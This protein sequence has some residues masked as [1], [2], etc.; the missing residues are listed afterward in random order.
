MAIASEG[1]G[2]KSGARH[3]REHVQW[4]CESDERRELGRA[5]G[6]MPGLARHPVFQWH[7]PVKQRPRGSIHTGV[8]GRRG[9]A[10]RRPCWFGRCF[11]QRRLSCESLL[12][13]CQTRHARRF[14]AANWTGGGPGLRKDT[15]LA[16]LSAPWPMDA[17][18][19]L[20][21]RWLALS[22]PRGP[23]RFVTPARVHSAGLPP[24]SD[25]R[26]VPAWG[27]RGKARRGFCGEEGGE[28]ISTR[29]PRENPQ[30]PRRAACEIHPVSTASRG[31][32]KLC[33]IPPD[34]LSQ[35]N[36]GADFMFLK[37][38]CS[39]SSSGLWKRSNILSS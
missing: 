12:E 21:T 28:K 27:R 13:P 29:C 7:N 4:T 25:D 37:S 14:L 38:I 30:F 11:S 36:Q 22:R 34:F 17:H 39:I 23:G 35:A 5:A 3:A 26:N 16:R 33:P 19:R 10:A 15:G 31:G 1:P 20:R 9:G 32:A 6:A 18:P 8:R 24:V 2:V